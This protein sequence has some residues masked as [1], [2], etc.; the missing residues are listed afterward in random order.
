[1][2]RK[3]GHISAKVVSPQGL[4]SPY[5]LVSHQGSLSTGFTVIMCSI[6]YPHKCLPYSCLAKYICAVYLGGCSILK[7]YSQVHHI[8]HNL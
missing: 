8:H 3:V 1:M 7:E 6:C 4:V 2:H 5:M